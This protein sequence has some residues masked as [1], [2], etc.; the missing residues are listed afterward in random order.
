MYILLHIH[1]F[2]Y[3]WRNTVIILNFQKIKAVSGKT[4]FL[5]IYPFCTPDSIC[6]NFGF[7]QGSFGN[8]ALSIVELSTKKQY[9]GFLKKIF[10]YQ[11]TCFKV[12]VLK[13]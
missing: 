7:R 8:V 1:L 10:V 12:E 2:A 6:L 5:M 13:S 4:P 3:L 9:S 11:K